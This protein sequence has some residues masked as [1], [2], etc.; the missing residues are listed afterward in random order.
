MK[1]LDLFLGFAYLKLEKYDEA[2]KDLTK[3]IEC[4]S[5]HTEAYYNRGVD[6]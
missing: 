2:I 6:L 5:N 3:A 1:N 4:D